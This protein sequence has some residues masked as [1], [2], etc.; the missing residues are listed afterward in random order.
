MLMQ[1]ALLLSFMAEEYSIVYMYHIFFILLSVDGHLSC[2]QVLAIVNSA[3]MKFGVHVSL[4]I[5]VFSKHMLRSGIAGSYGSSIFIFL[6]KCHIVLHSDCA[7]LYG[8]SIFICLRNCHIV[9]HSD[10]TNLYF[11]QQ[12]R[13]VPFSQHPLQQLLFVDFLVMA[14]LTGMTWYHI[15]FL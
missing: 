4:Q 12:Y 1:M 13:R 11:H 5:M 7:N 9:L 6:R 10:C 14:A 8:G 2:V 3:A 15:A